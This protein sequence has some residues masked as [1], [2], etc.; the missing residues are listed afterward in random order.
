MS[1]TT[2]H[3]CRSNGNPVK[4]ARVVLEFHGLLRGQTPSTY[5]DANG[6]AVI[7]HREPGQ[8]TVYV[9]GSSAGTV[10]APDRFVAYI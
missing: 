10:R 8:A 9:N 4:G 6:N 7:E 3:V 1:Y 2:V 5:T